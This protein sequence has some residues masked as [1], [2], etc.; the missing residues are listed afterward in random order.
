MT[1]TERDAR[2]PVPEKPN[3]D[4]PRRPRRTVTFRGNSYDLAALG[5]L[6]S[7]VL[8]LVSCLTLGQFAYCLP[9]LAVGLGLIGLLAGKDAVDPERTR[10]WSWLGIGGGG[11]VL[12]LGAMLFV[13]YFTCIF[14]AM[15]MSA[16]TW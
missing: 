6:A 11:L 12:L 1:H 3:K 9:F 10:L 8:V 14:F 4:A 16:R 2:N 5:A 7:G 15:L 13:F